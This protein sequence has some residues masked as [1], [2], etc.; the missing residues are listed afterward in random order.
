MLLKKWCPNYVIVIILLFIKNYDPDPPFPGSP[1]GDLASSIF[2]CAT[3]GS[4]F[5]LWARLQAHSWPGFYAFIETHT[6]WCLARLLL[7]PHRIWLKTA[8]APVSAS[9]PGRESRCAECWI[10]IGLY[11]RY[12]VRGWYIYWDF[13]LTKCM[14][15]IKIIM[16]WL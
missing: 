2:W 9:V 16:F 11:S 7:L 1:T 15:C 13:F 6:Q 4:C 12:I 8:G 14:E 5:L 3:I 10:D